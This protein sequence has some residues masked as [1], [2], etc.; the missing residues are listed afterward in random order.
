MAVSP[1]ATEHT[2]RLVLRTDQQE[3]S[4]NTVRHL[5]RPHTRGHAVSACSTGKT[6]FALRVAEDSACDTP[7]SGSAQPGPS[8]RGPP[9]CTVCTDRVPG[10]AGSGQGQARGEA[11]A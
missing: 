10:H 2:G 7:G 6:L 11:R 1:T 8:G 5:R 4:A 3:G 9:P